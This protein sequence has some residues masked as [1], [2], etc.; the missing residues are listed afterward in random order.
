[1]SRSQ[2]LLTL[3]QLLRRHRLP[4]S[5]ATL[6]A[7]TG[8]SLR[9]LYRDIATLQAEG[10]DIEGE[11]GIGYVLR[12]GYMLPPLMFTREE[13]EALML[14]FRFVEKR[15]DD[16]IASAARN[17]LAKIDA[18][19]P[20]DL[21][22]DM[23]NVALLV[24]PGAPIAPDRVD[25]QLLRQALRSERPLLIA[26]R[27]LRGD[28][29]SRTVWPCALTFFDGVRVLVAW[30]TLRED[31]R[32]F[33]TDRI[34]SAVVG[35]TRYPRRRTALLKEWRRQNEIPDSVTQ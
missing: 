15:T 3:L 21:R 2:R 20:E 8:V 27:D 25:L 4:V 22:S 19:L 17:A 35:E 28:L 14:G 18:V 33:R 10:A 6:A 34:E 26:Y 5:G 9:T 12:P 7:E 13:I 29:S 32:H 1:M 23:A 24:G 30:C 31:F 11:A 16:A